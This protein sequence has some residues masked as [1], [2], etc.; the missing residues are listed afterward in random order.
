MKWQLTFLIGIIMVVFSG[1]SLSNGSDEEAVYETKNPDAE[2]VL[3]LDSEANIFQFNDIIYQTNIDW[4]DELTVTKD[5]Q[6]GE[7]TDKSGDIQAFKNG[8]ANKLE[9]GSEIYSVQERED[10]LIVETEG[11][12]LKYLA[13]VEG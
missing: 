13:I 12:E 3:T 7:I 4:V 2:E 8:T 9:V 1:C 6:I 5:E 10:I 11:K